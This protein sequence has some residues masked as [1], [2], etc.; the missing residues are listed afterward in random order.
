MAISTDAIL[1]YG[2]LLDMDELGPFRVDGQ[3]DREHYLLTHPDLG[4][5]V[6]IHCSYDYPEYYLAATSSM[7]CANRGCPKSVNGTLTGGINPTWIGNLAE[8]CHRARLPFK[9]PQWWLASM[10]S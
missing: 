8:F 7:E 3:F 1:F 10:L 4:C 9:H 5:E 6:G 2:I